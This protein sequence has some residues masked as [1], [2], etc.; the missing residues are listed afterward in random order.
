MAPGGPQQVTEQSSLASLGVIPANDGSVRQFQFVFQFGSQNE[1]LGSASSRNVDAVHKQEL[2]SGA[3]PAQLQ[4]FDVEVRVFVDEGSVNIA[5]KGK[6]IS[7]AG[8]REQ[9]VVKEGDA[10]VSEAD[11]K[12]FT[13]GELKAKLSHWPKTT[14]QGYFADV[15]KTFTDS[16]TLIGSGLTTDPVKTLRYMVRW[17]VDPNQP[18]PLTSNYAESSATVTPSG[19]SASSGL[20]YRTGSNF[21]GSAYSSAAQHS[22]GPSAG[23]AHSSVQAPNTTE[24]G[25]EVRLFSDNGQVNINL[26]GRGHNVN[27][28]AELSV[29][30]AS[31]GS[32]TWGALKR[33]LP[34]SWPKTKDGGKTSGGEGKHFTDG[35]ALADVGITPAKDGS[36]RAFNVAFTKA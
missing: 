9:V 23:A 31:F 6:Y 17:D 30:E 18:P 10:I 20:V 19:S 32:F 25:I 15:K 34:S 27:A 22:R 26:S 29:P 13:W 2:T 14:S 1:S 28:N 11:Y 16:D 35:D 12:R 21:S 36:T 7:K 8:L 33:R 3:P 4:P 5:C 24:I